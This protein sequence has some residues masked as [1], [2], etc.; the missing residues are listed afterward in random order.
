MPETTSITVKKVWHD[1]GSNVNRPKSVI[2]KLNNGM[3][4]ELNEK[5]G[6]MATISG[7]PTRVNGKPAV[8]TWTEASVL[9]YQM[10]S[11]VT[12]GNVT[13]IT[14]KPYVPETILGKPG[15]TTGN[16]EDYYMIGDY[17]TAL[18]LDTIIN[19]VGDCFD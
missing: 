6:W 19:H 4:V 1:D 14:N 9:G 16:P 11:N 10:E 2:M 17:G 7:L 3:T 5:N 12:V 18:G 13:T 15:K 8:Y